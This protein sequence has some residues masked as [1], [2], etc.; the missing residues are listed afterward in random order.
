MILVAPIAYYE[1]KRGLLAVN[2]LKSLSELDNF[3][4][5]FGIGK[6]DNNILDDAAEIWAM[7]KKAGKPRDD[8]D[9]LI[10]AFCK[11][12]GFTLVTRNTKH[13]NTISGLNAQN[14]VD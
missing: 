4:R 11:T 2:A 14:W 5:A 8:A 7:H 13:F 3:C 12:N 1:V 10:A 9:I 6:L